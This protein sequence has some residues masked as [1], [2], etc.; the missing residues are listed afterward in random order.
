MKFGKCHFGAFKERNGE[1]YVFT[2]DIGSVTCEKSNK[3]V[4]RY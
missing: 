3:K 2:L 1:K 4:C